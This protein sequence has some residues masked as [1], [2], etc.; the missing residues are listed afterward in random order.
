MKNLVNDNAP[1]TTEQKTET[2]EINT[3]TTVENASAGNTET[4]Q[5]QT[6]SDTS[7]ETT[8]SAVHKTSNTGIILLII[9]VLIVIAIAVLNYYFNR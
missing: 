3:V 9:A 4:S 8:V 1:E 5:H 2:S 7:G 6:V